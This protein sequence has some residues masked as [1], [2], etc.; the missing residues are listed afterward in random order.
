MQAKQFR[1]Y[2]QEASNAIT[3]AWST[4]RSCI[5]VV[6]TGGGKTLIAEI[7]RASCRERV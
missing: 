1:P 4:Q 2:Q 6:A 7:G 3:K 5:A